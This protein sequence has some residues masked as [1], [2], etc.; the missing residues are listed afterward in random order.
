MLIGWRWTRHVASTEQSKNFCQRIVKIWGSIF[1][2][3]IIKLVWLKLEFIGHWFFIVALNVKSIKKGQ[4]AL[5]GMND[6]IL[7][8]TS[9]NYV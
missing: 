1:Y 9:I 6:K 3:L 8:E 2:K 5:Q 4:L 7:W